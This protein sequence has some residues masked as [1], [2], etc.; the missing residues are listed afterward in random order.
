VLQGRHDPDR[1]SEPGCVC[2]HATTKR[3]SPE[4]QMRVSH[5]TVSPA[6][7]AGGCS[8]RTPSV[9]SRSFTAHEEANEHVHMP[10][11]LGI[12]SHVPKFGVHNWQRST[13]DSTTRVTRRCAHTCACPATYQHLIRIILS[14]D[15]LSCRP[16]ITCVCP[17]L[18]QLNARY[19]FADRLLELALLAVTR[20]VL[21]RIAH[22]C[23][24]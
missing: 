14:I 15:V 6:W 7:T 10:S 13:P 18:F 19:S 3:D 21:T 23:S 22:F 2:G 16:A 17:V 8:C 20:R 12:I 11:H 5:L 1:L 4:L 9:N 24:A